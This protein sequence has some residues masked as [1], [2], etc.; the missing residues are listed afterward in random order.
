MPLK[1]ATRSSVRRLIG[2]IAGLICCT[3]WSSPVIAQNESDIP[4]AG[5]GAPAPHPLDPALS[6]AQESLHHIR[7]HVRDYTAVM[8]KRCRVQGRLSDHQQALV[9]IRN[10]RME[11]G[12]L[13]VPM[14]VYLKFRHPE[15]INGREVIWVEGRNGGKMVAHDV[16]IKGLI[17]VSLD[18]NGSI[19]MRGQRYPITEIGLE[20]LVQKMIERGNQDRMHGECQVER[21]DAARVNRRVCTVFRI[22]HPVQRPHFD[23]CRAE[24]FF[25]A[26]SKLPCRYA[27]WSWPTKA[28]GDLVLEE[29]YTYTDIQLNVGLS[30]KDFDP[31]NED[32]DF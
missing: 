17:R 3:E 12:Q 25:D 26:E 19:A 10:R 18:P 9:K 28:N 1:L 4:A 7:S 13:A 29:E 6:M 11:N 27:S 16:G 22:D 30:D 31:D 5:A 23:F 24:V 14:S 21:F 20:K 8:T 15:S 2:L 32:Y